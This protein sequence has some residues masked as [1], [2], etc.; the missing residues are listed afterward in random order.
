MQTDLSSTS[1]RAVDRT[2]RF[3][4]LLLIK[5]NNAQKHEQDSFVWL[6]APAAK[7]CQLTV[8]LSQIVV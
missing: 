6:T 8:V 1:Y 4:Y 2:E 3:L 5:Y 7:S